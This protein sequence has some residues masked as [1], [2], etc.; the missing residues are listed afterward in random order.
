MTIQKNYN[1]D[2]NNNINDKTR[3]DRSRND[4]VT[5]SNNGNSINNASY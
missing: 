1:D 5:A 4:D 3:D 2:N